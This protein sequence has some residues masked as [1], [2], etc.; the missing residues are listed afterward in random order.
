M[1]E[2]ASR[3]LVAVTVELEKSKTLQQ[4][5]NQ[6]QQAMNQQMMMQLC[7]NS[8]PLRR[9]SGLCQNLDCIK[10]ARFAHFCL[11][12][13]ISTGKPRRVHH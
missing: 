7:R 4:Q 9:I 3:K 13:K 1:E 5:V 12:P 6:Q 10:N 2:E 11:T 8:G